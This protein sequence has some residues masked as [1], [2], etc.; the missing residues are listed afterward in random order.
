MS[1]SNAA[2]GVPATPTTMKANEIAWLFVPQYYTF[3]NQDPGHLHCF[4]TK[5][6][7]MVHGDENEAITP[8][9]GQQEIHAKIE[10][11]GLEDTK[12]FVSN[13]DSHSSADGG[14]I[15][16]VLGELLN[17]SG[18][19]RPFAQTFFLAKQP[20]G[21]YVLNDIFRYLKDPTDDAEARE[22][23][24]A[25]RLPDAAKER[26]NTA[27]DS[28]G[29]EEV[30]LG[31]EDEGAHVTD[32]RMEEDKE[33]DRGVAAAAAPEPDS[34]LAA[35]QE[36]AAPQPA[37]HAHAKADAP[38]APVAPAAPAAPSV[39]KT[40][41]NLA[42][43]GAN[44]WGSTAWESRQGAS[45]GSTPKSGPATPTGGANAAAE[46]TGAPAAARASGTPGNGQVFVKNVPTRA[47]SPDAL[48]TALEAQFGSTKEC[49]IIASKGF[50]FVEFVDADAAR[51][52][53]TQSLPASQGGGGGVKVGD[54]AIIIEKRRPAE[55][56]GGSG[57][58]RGGAHR[59][60]RGGGVA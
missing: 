11:L 56:G 40:W 8:A 16:Q 12:V 48:K 31:A 41:A 21:Y 55:R 34:G 52:A 15:I 14:I 20:N 58:G 1:G 32:A 51:R 47:V 43:S 22:T 26:E 6:S 30:A 45:E 19:W 42:A 2:N 7:T 29:R 50:A 46:S 38:V 18:T 37:T 49:Q 5:Q 54:H 44:R 36:A 10:S 25:V 53:I 4:Y 3:M 17:K 39:P 24:A 35:A 57:R 9:Y 60:A 27:G 33:A 59:G 28:S 13:V 23:A